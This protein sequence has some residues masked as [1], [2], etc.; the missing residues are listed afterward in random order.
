MN[1]NLHSLSVVDQNGVQCVL[2]LL[3]LPPSQHKDA[4]PRLG[5]PEQEAGRRERRHPQPISA[6]RVILWS[7]ESVTR[8]WITNAV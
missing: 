4:V 2:L 5:Q 8:V 3:Q 1:L 7:Q 6:D